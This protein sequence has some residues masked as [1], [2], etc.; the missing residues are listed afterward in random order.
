[1][2]LIYLGKGLKFWV[3]LVMISRH[4]KVKTL[5]KFFNFP[6]FFIFVILS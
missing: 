6:S 4:L 3:F 5:A 1:M 2:K